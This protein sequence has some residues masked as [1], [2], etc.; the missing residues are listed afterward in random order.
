MKLKSNSDV[1]ST[2][3]KE[4]GNTVDVGAPRADPDAGVFRTRNTSN[5]R[6][7]N[8][9][10]RMYDARRN[11]PAFRT[12]RTTTCLNA[13]HK[14]NVI[15]HIHFHNEFEIRRESLLDY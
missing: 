9:S 2:C 7:A 13:G 14:G 15:S 3:S 4:R 8:P 12:W 6:D 10:P 1:K 11:K 5:I